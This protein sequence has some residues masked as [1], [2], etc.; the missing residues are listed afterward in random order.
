MRCKGA[1]G[2]F[3]EDEDECEEEGE[4]VLA[5]RVQPSGALRRRVAHDLLLSIS[6]SR[7]QPHPAASSASPAVPH[8]QHPDIKHD[9]RFEPFTCLHG[10]SMTNTSVGFAPLDKI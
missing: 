1:A 2:I 5:T 3:E 8:R 9:A 7:L 10:H 6:P 4:V